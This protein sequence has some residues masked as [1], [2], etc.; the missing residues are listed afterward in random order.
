VADIKNKFAKRKASV[1]IVENPD[2][3]SNLE[4]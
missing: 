1:F 2:K 4:Q 3:L